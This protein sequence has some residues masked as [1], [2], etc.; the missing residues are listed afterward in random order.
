MTLVK[1]TPKRQSQGT[2]SSSY[3]NTPQYQSPENPSDSSRWCGKRF[4]VIIG[5]IIVISIISSVIDNNSSSSYRNSSYT[6]SYNTTTN[7]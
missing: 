5:V 6:S 3:N 4:L 7:S 2:S 1:A